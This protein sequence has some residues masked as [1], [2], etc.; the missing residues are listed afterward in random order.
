MPDDLPL[1]D[2]TTE[3]VVLEGRWRIEK[4]LGRGAMGEVCLATDM[5]LD[6]KVAVK[7][8]LGANVSP[9]AILKEPDVLR[10]FCG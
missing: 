3:F 8:M 1:H 7:R 4:T 9:L 5:R 6:R 10:L 2:E